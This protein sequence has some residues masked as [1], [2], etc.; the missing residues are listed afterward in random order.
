[1]IQGCRPLTKRQKMA[2]ERSKQTAVSLKLA[3][4]R[5]RMAESREEQEKLRIGLY[6]DQM[7]T[8]DE[9][10]FKKETA[11]N[12]KEELKQDPYA[13]EAMN[14]IVDMQRQ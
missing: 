14:I 5:Q 4:M 11:L 6:D 2:D 10:D 9:N 13:G 12:W 3:D 1:M 8:N 7:E